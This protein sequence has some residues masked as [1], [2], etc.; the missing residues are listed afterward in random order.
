MFVILCYIS[1]KCLVG[2]WWCSE[3]LTPAPSIVLALCSSAEPTTSRISSPLVPPRVR[4]GI[5]APPRVWPLCSCLFH[6]EIST[7]RMRMRCL[8]TKVR[9]EAVFICLLVCCTDTHDTVLVHPGLC[10]W[11]ALIHVSAVK[12]EA[13]VLMLC[14]S[15][16]CNC[17]FK[18]KYNS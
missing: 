12:L 9:L 18:H 13:I 14:I 7:H 3:T 11:A 16:T 15:F 2:S 4:C 17:T 5:A 6:G 10:L 1:Y 8:Y